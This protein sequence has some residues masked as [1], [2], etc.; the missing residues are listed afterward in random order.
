MVRVRFHLVIETGR[1]RGN[2]EQEIRVIYGQCCFLAFHLFKYC[3][4]EG[5]PN[6]CRHTKSPSCTVSHTWKLL[7]HLGSTKSNLW[8]IIHDHGLNS[9]SLDSNKSFLFT[10]CA[11]LSSPSAIFKQYKSH[12]CL[13]ALAL[14]K[15]FSFY[16]HSYRS[17]K[18]V[19]E[20]G[21]SNHLSVCRYLRDLP[22]K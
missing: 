22:K 2:N 1:M 13:L 15:M 7:N 10:E 9:W 12:F 19:L 4:S 5:S 11:C 20:K 8:F 17:N 14:K 18:G 6:K 21:P 3:R 16:I